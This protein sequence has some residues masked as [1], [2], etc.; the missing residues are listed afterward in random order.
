MQYHISAHCLHDFIYYAIDR[1]YFLDFNCIWRIFKTPVHS[2]HPFLFAFCK[3]TE[4]YLTFK[5]SSD[6][7]SLYI[8]KM[9]SICWPQ[10]SS[11]CCP[12]VKLI[13]RWVTKFTFV[14]ISTLDWQKD[15]FSCVRHLDLDLTSISGIHGVLRPHTSIHIFPLGK[16]I[17]GKLYIF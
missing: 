17:I 15:K 12:H 3:Y 11:V 14:L 2:S 6:V 9:P 5:L 8:N 4:R 7:A 16:I 1:K 13:G 10:L